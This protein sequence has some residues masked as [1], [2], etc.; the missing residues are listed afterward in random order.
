MEPFSYTTLADTFSSI[1]ETLSAVDALTSAVGTV[2][3][4]GSFSSRRYNS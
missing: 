1:S 4:G 2:S 3:G